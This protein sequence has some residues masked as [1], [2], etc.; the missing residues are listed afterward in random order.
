MR[1]TG[2]I[3]HQR[4]SNTYRQMANIHPMSLNPFVEEKRL[5]QRNLERK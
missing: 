2:N 4:A 5:L 1:L 3:A